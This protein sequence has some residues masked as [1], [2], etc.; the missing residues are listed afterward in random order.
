VL[1]AIVV[2]AAA[3]VL[4]VA[5]SAFMWWA[6]RRNAFWSMAAGALLSFI[7]LAGAIAIAWLL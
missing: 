3:A 5:A 7:A 2:S 6:C 1:F 4:A